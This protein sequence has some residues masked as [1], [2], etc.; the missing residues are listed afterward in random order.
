[1]GNRLERFG[2]TLHTGETLTAENARTFVKNQIAASFAFKAGRA[3]SPTLSKS[4]VVFNRTITAKNPD[5]TAF[6]PAR[7]GIGLHG[8]GAP[9]KNEVTAAVQTLQLQAI[10]SEYS[11]RGLSASLSLSPFNNPYGDG[12]VTLR[13]PSGAETFNQHF[14]GAVFGTGPRIGG[15][16][17]IAGLFESEEAANG[18]VDY[19]FDSNPDAGLNVFKAS[20][21]IADQLQTVRDH[22]ISGGNILGPLKV[23]SFG[24]DVSGLGSKLSGLVTGAS[25]QAPAALSQLKTF[26]G[27]VAVDAV[28]RSAGDIVASLTRPDAGPIGIT[29]GVE[30]GA[31]KIAAAQ[32]NPAKSTRPSFLSAILSPRSRARIDAQREAL[33]K[34]NLTSTSRGLSRKKII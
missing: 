15:T 14:F 27:S 11:K 21:D 22:K 16:A 17:D 19:L 23:L 33:G 5:G 18:A 7:P 30:T 8:V 1:M 31:Q 3:S 29:S 32:A 4:G 2:F 25:S 34:T 28:G 12:D 26:A 9:T 10:N 6:V 13:V 24:L 20:Q